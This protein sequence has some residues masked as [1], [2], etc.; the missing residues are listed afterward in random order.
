[1]YTLLSKAMIPESGTIE[2]LYPARQSYDTRNWYN[3]EAIPC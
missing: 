3:R 2:R 1:M